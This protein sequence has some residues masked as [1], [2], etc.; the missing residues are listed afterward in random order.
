VRSIALNQCCSGTVCACSS[1]C[2]YA[3]L[4]NLTVIFSIVIGVPCTVSGSTVAADSYLQQLLLAIWL[5]VCFMSHKRYCRWLKQ[6]CSLMTAHTLA[7]WQHWS[8]LASMSRLLSYSN[9]CRSVVQSSEALVLL[10]SVLLR[11][12]SLYAVGVPH[13]LRRS[14]LAS[15]VLLV[16]VV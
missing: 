14:S 10:L 2:A 11:A 6:A 3:Q 12:A 1:C 7:Q 8:M 4:T 15:H 5:G 9:A 13:N 16:L